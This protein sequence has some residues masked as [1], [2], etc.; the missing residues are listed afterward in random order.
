MKAITVELAK[1]QL[2]PG[3]SLAVTVPGRLSPEQF[4]CLRHYLEASL[5]RGVKFV[6]L[7]AGRT[8]TKVSPQDGKPG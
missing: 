3:D 1:L 4:H 2:A 8:L 6:I 5:V 7:D